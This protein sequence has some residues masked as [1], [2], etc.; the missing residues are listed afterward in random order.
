MAVK[1]Y[2]VAIRLFGLFHPTHL[3]LVTNNAAALE[4]AFKNILSGNL[5]PEHWLADVGRGLAPFSGVWTYKSPASRILKAYWGKLG[6]E[7]LS[8]AEQQMMMYMAEGGLVPGMAA[9]DRLTIGRR[10]MDAV[11]QGKLGSAAFKL[12]FA[13]IG[14]L[15]YPMFH[16][17]IP[18]MKIM[19]F[20]REVT[21]AFKVNPDLVSDPVARRL[22]L[23]NIA[24]SVDN[25]FG[26]M[27][28]DT[29][30]WQR[31][32]KDIAVLNTLSVG[33]QMGLIREFGGGAV[34]VG[35]LALETKTIPEKIKAG[36]LDKALYSTFYIGLSA[37][38]GGLLMYALTGKWPQ[39]AL[40]YFAPQSG[41]ENEDGTPKRITTPMFTREIVAIDKHI[42]NEG[43]AAGL[44]KLA[45][46]KASGVVGL[47]GST[48]TGVDGLGRE[49]RDPNAPAYKQLEQTLA[50]IF[51]DIQPI[52]ASATEKAGEPIT[53][54]RGALAVAGF[55]PAPKYLMETA[56]IGD[57]KATFHKY[58]AKLT[59]YDQAAMSEDRA[60]LKKAYDE[61]SPEYDKILTKMEE[62]YELSP[63][64]SAKI[65]KGL[66]AQTDPTVRMFSRLPWKEQKRILD[67]HWYELTPDQQEDFLAKSNKAHIRYDY[68][69]PKRK[70]Q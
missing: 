6:K 66:A 33:W 19:A 27:S 8:A 46:N 58:Q 22:A 10:F 21:T 43:V 26:E 62:K 7:K 38:Y 20:T 4:R 14:S 54:V 3:G 67:K 11:E 44:S 1:N 48:I 50:Y 41:G 24:K 52:S 36:E 39:S 30:F 13:V 45:Q 64:E 34:Q 53:S 59:P 9:Q 12:P 5:S 60:K 69:P 15:Q 42:E 25:R 2:T 70:L 68:E 16:I 35:K 57:I 40:D 61:N 17:W 32:V 49:I 37:L 23:R 51:K 18:Q 55:Q 65:E 31:Y 29:M 63:E 28:Y 56:V 47:V